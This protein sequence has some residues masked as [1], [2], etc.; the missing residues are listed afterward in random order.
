MLL[1][2]KARFVVGGESWKPTR[3]PQMPSFLSQ[4][5]ET[6]ALVSNQIWSLCFLI[7][8]KISRGADESKVL[9]VEATGQEG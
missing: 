4:L 6:D 2:R 7:G 1:V 8:L 3:D 9:A 5:V